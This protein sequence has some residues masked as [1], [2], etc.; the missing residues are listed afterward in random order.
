MG[1]GCEYRR[2]NGR[3][4]SASPTRSQARYEIPKGASASATPGRPRASAWPCGQGFLVMAALLALTPGMPA[5]CAFGY[6]I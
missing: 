1:L 3:L 6:L 4:R 5:S 2:G